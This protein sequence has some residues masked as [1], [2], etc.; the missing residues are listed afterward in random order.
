MTIQSYLSWVQ[1]E[2]HDDVLFKQFENCFFSSI[3]TSLHE[4]QD[5][6][7][8]ETGDIHA[9]WLRDSTCQVH[10]LLPFLKEEP[11]YKRTVA[12]LIRMQC[13]FIQLDPYA[14]AFLNVPDVPR[15]YVDKTTMYPY[16]WE[17]KF[18]LDSLCY[19]ISLAYDYWKVTG[20]TNIFDDDFWKTIHI[21]VQTL[22]TEQHHETQSTYRFERP[23]AEEWGLLRTETLQR[24]GKGFPVNETGMVWSGFRPSDD[25]CRFHYNI[26]QNMFCSEALGKIM[27][28]M[29]VCH[30]DSA[31]Y[32]AVK[33]LRFE[34][35]YG[36]DAYGIVETELGSVYAYEVDGYGNHIL[37]DDANVPSLLSVPYIGYHNLNEAVYKRTRQM[38]LSER[39][40]Y[41]YQGSVFKGI[42]SPHTWE[43]Y[44]WPMSLMIQ[45]LTSE[46]KEE[47]ISLLEQVRHACPKNMHESV[48]VDDSS[49]YT[50]SL[51][52]W[53]D[54]LF[55]EMVMDIWWPEQP[56]E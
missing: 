55:A 11:Q 40:P 51:F 35:D 32:E 17:R 8:V 9:M 36:I 56:N 43:G 7:Y 53:A 50:R 25:A 19:V 33:T 24:R 48:N 34:I 15:D 54:A 45:S 30:L 18:E 21:I 26:P 6:A 22:Q 13:L 1:N 10:H 31:L 29:E 14:N 3:R 27:T 23:I 2:L 41:Y 4:N 44:A 16:V 28:I 37:M 5:L 39:N 12:K 49:Q 38:I 52:C 20:D 46:D 47:K 42:G